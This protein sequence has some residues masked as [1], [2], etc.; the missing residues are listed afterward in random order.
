MGRPQQP[1]L[2]RSGTTPLDPDS[3]ASEVEARG[4]LPADDVPGGPVP[5]ANRPGH[6]PEQDQDK[7]DARAFV[8]RWQ[9]TDR[10]EAAE[11]RRNRLGPAVAVAA[12]VGAAVGVTRAI[13]RRFG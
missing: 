4:P 9:A 13:R 12:G 11:A 2:N 10:P 6:R 5:E 8:A 7:P 1:E 3:L